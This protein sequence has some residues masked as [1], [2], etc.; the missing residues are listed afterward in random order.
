MTI[1]CKNFA[2]IANFLNN[3]RRKYVKFKWSRNCQVAFEQIK[4]EICLE[5]F[6]GHYDPK[7]PLIL[8]SDVSPVGVVCVLS[9][10]YP[11]GSE[12]PI[13]LASETLTKTEQKC[14]QIDKDVLAILGE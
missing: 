7:L 5:K 12:R 9:H 13:A 10:R 2:T 14:S 8:A 4:E 3:L 6:L 1:F 11:G